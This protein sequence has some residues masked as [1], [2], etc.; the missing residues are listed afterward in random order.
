[1][2]RGSALSV[3]GFSGPKVIASLTKTVADLKAQL[4]AGGPVTQAQLDALDASITGA[5]A[6][7]QAQTTNLTAAIQ[8]AV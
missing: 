3:V 6:A 4:A 5:T 7:I 1:M 8:P 2:P